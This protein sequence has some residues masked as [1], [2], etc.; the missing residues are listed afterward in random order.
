MAAKKFAKANQCLQ[1]FQDKRENLDAGLADAVRQRI[2]SEANSA[3]KDEWQVQLDAFLGQGVLPVCVPDAVKTY[4]RGRRTAVAQAEHRL[5]E[6]AKLHGKE[7]E[8][9][10]EEVAEIAELKEAWAW[11]DLRVEFARSATKNDGPWKL[12]QGVIE[13]IGKEVAVG[14]IPLPL[15]QDND[16]EL[17]KFQEYISWWKAEFDLRLQ[18]QRV[19]EEGQGDLD[20]AVPI[21][22][23]GSG[24]RQVLVRIGSSGA[25]VVGADGSLSTAGFGSDGSAEVLISVRDGKLV[26]AADG[27]TLGLETK[28]L[29][30][31]EGTKF[32]DSGSIFLKPSS[33]SRFRVVVAEILK[34]KR[35]APTSSLVSAL[36]PKDSR[37]QLWQGRVWYGIVTWDSGKT[38]RARVRI[39][40]RS[41]DRLRLDMTIGSRTWKIACRKTGTDP[42]SF[43]LVDAKT[44][45]RR[46]GRENGSG[47]VNGGKL[48][49]QFEWQRDFGRHDR[50]VTTIFSTRG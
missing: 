15:W 1:G 17:N 18:I 30:L 4:Q 45:G 25:K 26:L 41:G 8:D 49:W 2:G 12:V 31:P 6:L 7:M 32:E 42:N 48:H 20:I 24:L 46:L 22:E 43:E 50:A 11:E 40:S 27:Q 38:D 10:A 14:R 21:R 37:D 9:Y 35:E 33:G 44:D 34:V 36:Q 19:L 28:G 13:G 5:A 39:A 16:P 3:R 23:T 29:K 47:G